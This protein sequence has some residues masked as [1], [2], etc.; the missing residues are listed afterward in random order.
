[1]DEPARMRMP[2]GRRK[3]DREAQE[4]AYWKWRSGNTVERPA[5]GVRQYQ[6]HSPALGA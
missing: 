1:M 6:Q 4:R 3:P 2:E 5:A